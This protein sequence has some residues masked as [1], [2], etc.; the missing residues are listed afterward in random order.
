MF[1]RV[2]IGLKLIVED[3]PTELSCIDIDECAEN[4]DGCIQICTN[5]AGSYQ[6]SCRSGYRLANNGF[7]CNGEQLK[8]EWKILPL[9]ISLLA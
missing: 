2:C 9:N 7:Q 1:T 3:T 5:T 8:K 6:C 4:S